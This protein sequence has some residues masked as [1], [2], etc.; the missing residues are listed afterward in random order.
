MEEKILST[1]KN[2]MA[3]LL[4][5]IA[6]E[7]LSVLALLY[8]IG[9]GMYILTVAAFVIICTAWIPL[10]GLRVLKPEEALVITLFGNY[11]GTTRSTRSLSASIRPRRRSSDRAVTWTRE[12]K[13]VRL[14]A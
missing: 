13:R 14:P 7:L 5:C 1:R 9:S 6:A 4:G 11:K 10:V 12:Q 8:S 2:G 3:V